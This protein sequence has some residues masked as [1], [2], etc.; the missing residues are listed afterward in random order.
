[1][2]VWSPSF[3]EGNWGRGRLSQ[4]TSNPTPDGRLASNPGL[5]DI[6]AHAISL[7]CSTMGESENKTHPSFRGFSFSVKHHWSKEPW[8]RFFLCWVPTG[9]LRLILKLTVSQEQ[10]HLLSATFPCAPSFK[11]SSLHLLT[12]DTSY[13]RTPAPSSHFSQPV[14]L[15]QPCWFRP[16]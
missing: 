9:S 15:T 16:L 6:G 10:S 1:M 12:R 3:W 7:H 4:L 2:A 14:M 13:S 11:N 5:P 8:E